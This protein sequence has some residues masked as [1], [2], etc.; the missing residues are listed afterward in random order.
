MRILPPVEEEMRRVIRDARA[1]DPLISVAG[2][3][4]VLEQRFNRGFSRKY[5]K[6][7]ADKVHRQAIMQA[8]RTQIGERMNTTREKFRI[9]S[10]RL[11]QVIQAPSALNK[12]VI[13]ASKNFAMLELALMQAE[14]TNGF[15]KQ[16]MDAIVR[17][18]RYDPLPPE[19]RGIVVAAWI[20]GNMVPREAIESMV[21]AQLRGGTTSDAIQAS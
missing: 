14:I 17:E 9:A 21:P 13:E 5:V 4:Q 19:V 12:D 1:A 10:N 11:L 20:R 2:L 15:Y 8:D 7:L 18:F 16:P 3:E 6:K